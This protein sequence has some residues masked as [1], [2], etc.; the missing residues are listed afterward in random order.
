MLPQFKVDADGG[1]TLYIQSG[2]PGGDQE[3]NWLPAP[4]GPFAVFM[5]LYWPKTE[6]LDGTWK[7][8]PLIESD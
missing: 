6:A 8:P 5:R 1:I 4:S 2:S 7:H 3:A